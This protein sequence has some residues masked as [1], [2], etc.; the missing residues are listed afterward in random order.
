[1]HAS[2]SGLVFDEALRRRIAPVADRAARPLVRLGIR[3]DQLTA[4]GLAVGL[5]AAAVLAMGGSPL[6]AGTLFLLNRALD[7]LDGP[8]ARRTPARRPTPGGPAWGG[9][10]DL[11]ADVLVYVAV[12]L[13]LA[14]DRSELWPAAAV[15]CAAIAVNLVT[16]LAGTGQTDDG[17][18]VALAPGLVEGTETIVVY[19]ALIVV[20]ALSPGLLWV[21]A[22][23]VA[24]TAL[25]RLRRLRRT[26]PGWSDGP[27]SPRSA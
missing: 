14:A 9:V 22:G 1:M 26:V 18:A 3:P 5:A 13:G 24:L 10:W 4:L 8:L 17:R 21:F 25:D 12:P 11:T 23:L 15:L 16:V 27:G 20:P 6:L 19:T 7:G 2:D